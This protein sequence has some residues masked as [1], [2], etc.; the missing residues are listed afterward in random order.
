[1]KKIVKLTESDLTLI[2][3]R[4]I[5][6]QNFN[7]KQFFDNYSQKMASYLKGKTFNTVAYNNDDS[8]GK[9][10]YPVIKFLG[11][12]DRDHTNDNA[13]HPYKITEFDIFFNVQIVKANGLT[14]FR[15]NQKGYVMMKFN[16]KGGKMVSFKEVVLY[17]SDMKQHINLQGWTQKD[18]GGFNQ[19]GFN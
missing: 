1:M 7:G 6:E 15:D 17:S 18:I 10:V 13:I 3:K 11:Y 16:Y 2:V 4:V 5:M 14:N 8:V 12:A 19:W 9:G